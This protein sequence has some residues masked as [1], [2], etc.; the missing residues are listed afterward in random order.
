MAVGDG[1]DSV[2]H[3]G[4]GTGSELRAYSAVGVRRLVLAEGDSETA[5]E[6]RTH[7]LLPADAEVIEQPIVPESGPV[8]WYRYNLPMLS[9]VF[10][11]GEMV[12]IYPRLEVVQ[13][14]SV[15]GLALRELL[16]RT[17]VDP[18]KPNLL[19][20]DVPGLEDA[21]LAAVPAEQLRNFE[22][23]VVRGAESARQEGS[24]PIAE[25]RARLQAQGYRVE[26]VDVA[27][28]PEWPVM[29]L[30]RDDAVLENRRMQAELEASSQLVAKLESEFSELAQRTTELEQARSAAEERASQ[31]RQ[32]L[33]QTREELK[34]QQA[35]AAKSTDLQARVAELERALAEAE[36]RVRQSRQEVERTAKER[37][38]QAE[39]LAALEKRSAELERAR[40]EADSRAEQLRRELAQAAQ[41]RDEQAAKL[42]ELQARLAEFERALAE[43]QERASQARRELEQTVRERDELKKRSDDLRNQLEESKRVLAELREDAADARRA[44]ALAVKLQTI[45]EADLKD[46]QSRYEEALATQQSQHQLLQKLGERLS[47]A[48][49]YFRQLTSDQPA[50]VQPASNEKREALA[51]AP[52]RA[53]RKARKPSKPSVPAE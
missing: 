30:R 40:A 29:V 6:L 39:K 2:L 15:H 18:Y 28:D 17:P 1:F 11:P 34:Q 16:E 26:I 13:Q 14:E 19:V 46:L 42:S 37:D 49:G 31:S 21:L 27:S 20:L 23:L 25:S 52:P 10:P 9:G 41:L 50:M 53:K 12:A 7:P 4:A 36:E 48:A 47:V 32:E 35:L 8:N 5:Q 22:W 43:A 3:I 45:R 51:S 44:A 24:K 38:A 33:E